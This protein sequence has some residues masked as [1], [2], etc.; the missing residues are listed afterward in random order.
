MKAIDPGL[1]YDI[2]KEDYLQF[3]CNEGYC[4]NEIRSVSGEN[5]N[6]SSKTTGTI[7]DLNYPSIQLRVGG[8]KSFSS[9]F[10]RSVTNVGSSVSTYKAIVKGHPD[11]QITVNPS[12]LSLKSLNEKHSFVVTVTGKGL[13]TGSS[14]LSTQLVWSDGVHSVRSPVVVYTQSNP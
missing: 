14:I 4:K 2:T 13:P 6:C 10:S 3:L 11:L 1:V 8:N 12:V 7:G 5:I 9:N